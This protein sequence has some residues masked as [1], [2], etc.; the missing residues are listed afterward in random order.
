MKKLINDLIQLQ[1]LLEARAQQRA[2]GE[3]DRLGELEASIVA[4]M[5][6]LDPALARTFIRLHERSHTAIVP[7][8][9]GACSG[10][11]MTL[12][13]SLRPQVQA[14]TSLQQCPTCS[15]YLYMP[16]VV[17]GR[18]SQRDTRRGRLPRAGIARFS[19][20][21]LMLP[22]LQAKDRDG[23]LKEICDALS[24]EGFVDPAVDL[25]GLALRREAIVPTA[26][27]NGL[28]FPHVRGVEGGGLTLALGIHRKGVRFTPSA[29]A[30][31]RIIFFVIIPSASSA[32]YLSLLA[33][34]TKTFGTVEN[35]KK[36]LEAETATALWK[37]LCQCTRRTIP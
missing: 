19:S 32:F 21:A 3:E 37:A 10:C 30:L 33:G 26:L 8:I 1:E 35:R 7:V 36:L 28:A 13:I 18:P 6:Q 11:G 9:H 5:Q 31:T 27:D 24:R 17:A 23:V 14:A 4:M 34:L 12:P 16:D 20:P 22:R 15:R 29:R 25:V 2:I